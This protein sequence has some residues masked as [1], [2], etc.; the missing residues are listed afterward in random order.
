MTSISF[1][2]SSVL[3]TYRITRHSNIY[4]HV[5]APF[6]VLITYRITRHSNQC[7]GCLFFEEGFNYLQNNKTLK[8][9]I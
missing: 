1:N 3:I 5:F 6:E 9:Q 7:Q 8:P 4:M 2:C